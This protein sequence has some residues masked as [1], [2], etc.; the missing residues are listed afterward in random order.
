MHRHPTEVTLRAVTGVPLVRPGDDLAT[1][2]ITALATSDIGV[3]EQD[4]IVLAQKIVSKAEGRYVDLTRVVPSDRATTLANVV[5]KDPR[6]VEVILS[7]STEVLR[8]RPGLIISVHRL[9]FVM[10]NAGVDRSNVGGRE[11]V[12][13]LPADPD[14][15]CGHLR[16]QLEDHFGVRLGVII[17]DSIGRAWRNGVIGTALGAAGV[18]ALLDLRGQQD[19][20]GRALE[21]TQVGLAD[22]IAAAASLV[23]GQASE[24]LPLVVVSGLRWTPSAPGARALI[25]SKALDLF[26]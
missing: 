19:L 12:L 11:C 20:F 9:G 6:V 2:V 17:N 1:T 16:R 14:A 7:E 23:M 8:Y 13:L 24:R 18:P 4:V 3:R 22:E 15:T 21:T 26:R 25:R 5:E 10:A